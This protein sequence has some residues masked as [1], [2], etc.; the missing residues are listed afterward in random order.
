MEGV[1]E[2]ERPETGSEENEEDVL[3]EKEEDENERLQNER[4]ILAIY[5]LTLWD[6]ERE[7]ERN[8]KREHGGGK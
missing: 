6:R 8:E 4:G 3:V 2:G 1:R 7:R 5:C